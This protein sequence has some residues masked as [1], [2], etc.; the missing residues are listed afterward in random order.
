[1]SDFNSDFESIL[2]EAI[3]RVESGAMV[4]AVIASYPP[5]YRDELRDMLFVV[6]TVQCA[7][8]QCSPQN[9]F[10]ALLLRQ[11]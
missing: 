5:Q 9:H 6:D 7:V 4:D 2:A 11:C 1:M 8:P 10:L 3:E